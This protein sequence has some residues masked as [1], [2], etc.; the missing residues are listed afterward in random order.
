MNARLIQTNIRALA[1]AL[2]QANH[3]SCSDLIHF[4]TSHK[5]YRWS[6]GHYVLRAGCN[7]PPAVSAMRKARERLWICIL[8]VSRSGEIPEPTVIVRMIENNRYTWATLPW[9]FAI[10][11]ALIQVK[12]RQRHESH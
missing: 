6:V 8:W 9:L 12:R 3:H 11:S 2:A 10:V 4:V 7:S 5:R 1:L